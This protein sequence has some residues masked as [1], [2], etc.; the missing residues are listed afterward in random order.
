MVLRLRFE[1]GWAVPT[2][3]KRIGLAGNPY[4][5]LKRILDNLKTALPLLEL[6]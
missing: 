4:K 6:D 3:A 1:E 5:Y 2:I